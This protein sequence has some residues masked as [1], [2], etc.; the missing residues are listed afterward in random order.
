L[1]DVKVKKWLKIA[2]SDLKLASLA[3]NNETEFTLQ[4][5]FHSQQCVEK[6]LK[7]FL[8]HNNVA[9]PKTHDIE[10]L[11]ERCKEINSQFKYLDSGQLSLYAVESRYPLEYT[12]PSIEEAR[13]AYSIA[14][15]VYTFVINE[16]NA[17]ESDLTLF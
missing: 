3:F 4:I 9:F 8:V 16:L 2:K 11:H 17:D 7:A 15:N 1:I 14:K 5:C 10:Y 6:S 13:N 12:D